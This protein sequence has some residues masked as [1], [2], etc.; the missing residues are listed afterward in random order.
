MSENIDY[1][2][3]QNAIQE[4]ISENLL[5]SYDFESILRSAK[6]VWDNTAVQVKAT[7][8]TMVF[9]LISYEL[10]DYTGNDIT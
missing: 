6:L 1:E 5:S 8:F 3:L 2:T 4:Q 7:D 9:D 10:L